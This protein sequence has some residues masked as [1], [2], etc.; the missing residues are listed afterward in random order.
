MKSRAPEWIGSTIRNLINWVT[1]SLH[2]AHS[3]VSHKWTSLSLHWKEQNFTVSSDTQV[4]R[5]GSVGWP[6]PWLCDF[7]R[8]INGFGWAKLVKFLYIGINRSHGKLFFSMNRPNAQRLRTVRRRT[9]LDIMSV[10]AEP[11]P[12][13][14]WRRAQEPAWHWGSQSSAS[15]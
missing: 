6:W 10:H 3:F 13:Q 15:H 2:H 7:A 12:R 14:L 11:L 4:E 5:S 8:G 1:F 9:W